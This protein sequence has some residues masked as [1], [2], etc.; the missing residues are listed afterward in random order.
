MPANSPTGEVTRF[1]VAERV[2]HW[3]V[4][5][6]FLYL[7]LTGLAIWSPR[8]FWLSTVFGGGATIAAWHPWAGLVFCVFFGRMFLAWRPQMRLDGEDRR[9]LGQIRRYAVHDLSGLPEAGRFNGGQK[10]LF[11]IQVSAAVLLLASGLVLWWPEWTPS[12]LRQAGVLLHP[13]V[14][15]LAIGGLILHV[16]MGTAAVPGAFRG[17]VRGSVTPGWARSHHPKW[18]RQSRGD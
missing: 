9:W 3:A 5:L 12:W 16:Y 8:L 7:A 11:W 6:T 13:A 15:M 14:A 17:M 1:T 4:A 10:S 2:V 18:Y